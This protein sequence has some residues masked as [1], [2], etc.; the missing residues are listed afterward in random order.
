MGD[1]AQPDSAHQVLSAAV[2]SGSKRQTPVL[3]NIFLGECFGEGFLGEGGVKVCGPAGRAEYGNMLPLSR[4]ALL[5]IGRRMEAIT[6]AS[7]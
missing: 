2:S 1:L 5:R 4:T 3:L 6:S 7:S